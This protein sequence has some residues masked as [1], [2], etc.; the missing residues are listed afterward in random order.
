VDIP[1]QENHRREEPKRQRVT[2]AQWELTPEALTKLLA[3]FSPNEAEA[4][5]LYLSF[6]LKL[7]RFFEWKGCRDA[8]HLVD[9]TF[10]RVA[11]KL[12]EERLID[13]VYAFSR[14]VAD[15]VLKETWK[16][17]ERLADEE[18]LGIMFT[19][20]VDEDDM[21]ERRLKCLDECLTKETPEN[22][23]LILEYFGQNDK[24][25]EI[26][27]RMAALLGIPPNALRIRVHRIRERLE[28]CLELCM[29]PA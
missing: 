28:K 8:E 20:P 27:R 25:K 3:A 7:V 5:K 17:Q 18:T 21:R 19:E 2:H 12:C 14:R 24:A 22:R 10:N 1:P 16:A 26:R 6:H 13:N 4:S 29:T 9:V 11:R 15:I 23:A